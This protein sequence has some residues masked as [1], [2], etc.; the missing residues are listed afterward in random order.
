MV[1]TISDFSYIFLL[2]SNL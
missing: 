1:L 2:E